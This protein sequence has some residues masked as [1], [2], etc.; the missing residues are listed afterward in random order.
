LNLGTSTCLSEQ[1]DGKLN[2]VHAVAVANGGS[3][4][5]DLDMDITWTA[6]EQ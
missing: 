5:W 6:V 4:P 2:P 3:R 1:N